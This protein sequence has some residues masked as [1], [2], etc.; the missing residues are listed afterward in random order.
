MYLV[1]TFKD[2]LNIYHN[3]SYGAHLRPPKCFTYQ[4]LPLFIVTYK[5]TIMMSLKMKLMDRVS[6]SNL[7]RA[8]LV[9]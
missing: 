2:Y 5:H 1:K 9:T 6:H 8:D 7:W 3:L 4:L